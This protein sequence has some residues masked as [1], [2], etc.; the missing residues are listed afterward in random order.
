MEKGNGFYKYVNAK[1]GLN[2][3]PLLLCW[4]PKNESNRASVFLPR[5]LR[6]GRVTLFIL[7]LWALAAWGPGELG[8]PM[9]PPIFIGA[10]QTDYK[11]YLRKKT[12]FGVSPC[13]PF[14]FLILDV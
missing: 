7:Y 3:Y 13:Y 1:Q 14:Q 6:E 5:A 4:V 8:K 9:S 10:E 12:A 2:V 11:L